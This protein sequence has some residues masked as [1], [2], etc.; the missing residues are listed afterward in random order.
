[1][2]CRPTATRAAKATICSS[3][4]LTTIGQSPGLGTIKVPRGSNRQSSET[5]AM[6]ERIAAVQSG[7]T[8][9]TIAFVMAR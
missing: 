5:P 1:M 7:G 4:M 2:N 3:A 8:C 9:A 6:A